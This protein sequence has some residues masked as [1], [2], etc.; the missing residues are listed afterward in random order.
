MHPRMREVLDHVD[1]AHDELRAAAD[2]VPA[3]D[4]ERAPANGGWSVA[5]VVD[6]VAR[7]DRVIAGLIGKLLADARERGPLAEETETGSV[8]PRAAMA[9]AADR[10]RKLA[11]PPP[12]HPEPDVRYE[13]AC[14]SL[15]AAQAAV[16]EVLA[17]AD[18]L[19]LSSIQFPH[20]VM[21]VLNVYEWGMA[22]V[23]GHAARHAEQV[24]ETAAAFATLSG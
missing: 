9:V 4:R 10:S 22:A 17:S 24:R 2:A 6:H 13:D 8:A 20:P 16:R 23:G 14:A 11:S 15:A 1:A 21:G 18:G 5:Q 19:A 3:E 7:V 12:S